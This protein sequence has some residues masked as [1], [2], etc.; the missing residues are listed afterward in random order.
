MGAGV[1]HNQLFFYKRPVL[2]VS[3]TASMGYP[4][5]ARVP[6]T[7]IELPAGQ[8]FSGSRFR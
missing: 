8:R 1:N 5:A 3:D 2:I 7:A 4:S 6:G